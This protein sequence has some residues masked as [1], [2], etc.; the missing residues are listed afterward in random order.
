[1]IF[2]T[3]LLLHVK[4]VKVA[5]VSDSLQ[6]HTVHGILQARILKWVVFPFSRRSSQPRYKPRSPMLQADSLLS[7]QGRMFY[8]SCVMVAVIQA[9][10]LEWVTISFSRVSSQSRDGTQVSHIA[11]RFFSI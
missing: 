5:V 7:H 8:F 1:M 3:Y 11:D 10:I 2:I 9:R 4:S 6:P